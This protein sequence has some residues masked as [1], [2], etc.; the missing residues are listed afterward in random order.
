[1]ARRRATRAL[2]GRGREA[3]GI[4]SRPYRRPR[5]RP[6]RVFPVLALWR[7][8]RRSGRLYRGANDADELRLDR[9]AQHLISRAH[10]RAERTAHLDRVAHADL[11]RAPRDHGD[12]GGSVDERE[13]GVPGASTGA[14]D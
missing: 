8:D 7:T 14:L 13:G 5:S 2:P 4:A 1:G 6:A 9:V 3:R 10:L 11:L 12:A